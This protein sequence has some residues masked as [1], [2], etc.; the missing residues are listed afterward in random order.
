MPPLAVPVL[1][2]VF[3][4]WSLYVREGEEHKYCINCGGSCACLLGTEANRIGSKQTEQETYPEAIS[5]QANYTDRR[6]PRPARLVPTFAVRE[7]V[8]WLA[9]RILTAV[10]LS[11]LDRRCYSVFQVAP[12]L[13]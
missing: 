5:P 8:A 12:H 11:L 4:L 6:P 13:S 7:G 2:P 10:N 3:L 9:Q 1:S